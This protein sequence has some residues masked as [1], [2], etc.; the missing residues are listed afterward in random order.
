MWE[1][2]IDLSSARSCGFG[3]NPISAQDVQAWLTMHDI[4]SWRWPWFWR[5]ITAC[6][7]VLLK[8]HQEKTDA[9]HKSVN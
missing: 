1:A 7:Q 2:F 9:K 8:K 5:M 6:D 3:M 4:P